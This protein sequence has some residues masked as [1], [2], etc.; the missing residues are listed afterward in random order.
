MG[1]ELRVVRFESTC[2]HPAVRMI[3]RYARVAKEV[4]F[5]ICPIA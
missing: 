2:I 4:I 3:A 5:A 1:E